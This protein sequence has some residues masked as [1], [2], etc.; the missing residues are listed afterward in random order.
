MADTRRAA[1]KFLGS[2]VLTRDRAFVVDFDRQPRLLH[3]TTSDLPRLLRSLARLEAEGAT[4]LYDA[5]VF[6]ILQFEREAGRR[7]LVV[8]TDGD[9]YDSR[10]GPK[11]CVEL[12][13]TAGVPVYI[14]GLGAL[15]TLRRTYSKKELRKVTEET[16]GRLYFVDSLDELDAAYA[17][18]N[19]ELR[20]QYSLSFYA[21]SDLD[22]A[23][24]RAVSVEIRRPGH[25]A[26]TV[27]GS[28]KSVQ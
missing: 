10:F 12:A 15:D 1:V 26:R 9:D 25:Q 4:A 17:Q 7:A 22:A 3:P 21:D 27:V 6:S 16:G 13:R 28:G 19:A 23:E 20:S 14:I 5:I 8:L 2:T 11:Y 18:I 24:R